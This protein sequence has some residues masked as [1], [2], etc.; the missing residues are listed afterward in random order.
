MRFVGFKGLGSIGVIH[1][2][3]G[4]ENGNYH[5]GFRVEDSGFKVLRFRI[6]GKWVWAKG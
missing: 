1:R 3:N 6:S 2:D 4:T 5:L